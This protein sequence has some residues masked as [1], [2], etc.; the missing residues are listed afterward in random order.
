MSG[1]GTQEVEVK[2]AVFN[3]SAVTRRL[4]ELGFKVTQARSFE[5]NLIFDT[6]DRQLTKVGRLL[7]LRFQNGNALLT[8]KGP[9][10]KGAYKV[11]QETETPVADGEAMKQILEE[12]GFQVIFRYEK[13]RTCYRR[14]GQAGEVVLD[15]TPIGT[16]LELEGPPGWI[17]AVA[18]E[19]GYQSSDYITATYAE[20]YREA[21]HRLGLKPEWMVFSGPADG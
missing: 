6:P 3:L 14:E 7:R 17:D 19:L 11:R 1:Q 15:E 2:L 10:H 4:E 16:Y 18:Q 20:L 13:Y 12:L 21:R 5:V 9:A 8:F